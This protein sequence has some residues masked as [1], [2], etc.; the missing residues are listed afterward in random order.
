M[1]TLLKNS[2]IFSLQ[3]NRPFVRRELLSAL[4]VPVF[5]P[6]GHVA[7]S[8]GQEA[9][10]T[11]FQELEDNVAQARLGNGMCLAQV[12]AMLAVVLIGGLQPCPEQI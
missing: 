5:L 10:E 3:V 7:R 9:F 1:P 4:G 11:A 8:A 2:K 12:G 6:A